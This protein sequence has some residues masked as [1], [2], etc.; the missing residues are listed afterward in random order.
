MGR[1]STAGWWATP[2]VNPSLPRA[3]GGSYPA[4]LEGGREKQRERSQQSPAAQR[5]DR[6]EPESRPGLPQGRDSRAR[7]L[8]ERRARQ[9]ESRGTGRRLAP[10]RPKAPAGGV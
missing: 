4:V 7:D 6:Q 2:P 3:P 5:Q 8:R 10:E 1:R 9:P